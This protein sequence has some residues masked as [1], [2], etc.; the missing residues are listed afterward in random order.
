M[1]LI[2]DQ[3][4]N[5]NIGIHPGNMFAIDDGTIGQ[6]RFILQVREIK[7]LLVNPYGFLLFIS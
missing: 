7:W 4:N 5:N 3:I 6:V 2:I 1:N